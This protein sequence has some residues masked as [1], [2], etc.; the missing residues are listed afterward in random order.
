MESIK[1]QIKNAKTA[2]EVGL[3]MSL[4]KSTRFT[5]ASPKTRRQWVRLAE[6]RVKQ[7]S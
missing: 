7:L 3:V 2:K 4:A 1:I 5:G 6:S